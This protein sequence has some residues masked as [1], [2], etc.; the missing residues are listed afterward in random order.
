MD[1]KGEGRNVEGDIQDFRVATD[2]LKAH[3]H[4]RD[5]VRRVI[6]YRLLW[7]IA[8]LSASLIAGVVSGR[9]ELEA[10]KDIAGIVVGPIIG[11]FAIVVGFFFGSE[12]K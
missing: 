5:T 6:A 11:I 1:T 2:N 3:T 8:L 12:A 9:L 7:L 10:A 4:N